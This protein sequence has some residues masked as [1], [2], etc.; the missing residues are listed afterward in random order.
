MRGLRTRKKGKKSTIV[1]TSRYNNSNLEFLKFVLVI[2]SMANIRL[3]K[4][5]R[6]TQS[7]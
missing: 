1:Y 2:A 4:R 7:S 6:K 3:L 5:A